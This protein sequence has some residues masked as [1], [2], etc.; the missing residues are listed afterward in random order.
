MKRFPRRDPLL[1]IRCYEA[2]TDRLLFDMKVPNPGYQSSVSEWSPEAL[3]ASKTSPPV[4]AVLKHGPDDFFVNYLRDDDL[5]VTSTNPSWTLSQLQRSAWFSDATG[6]RTD[7]LVA[8][9]SPF[10]P[11]WKLTV[12]VRRNA[13]ARFAEGESWRSGLVKLPAEFTAEKLASK[14]TVAGVDFDAIW[15]C[16]AG[17]MHDHGETVTVH[18]SASEHFNQGD[19]NG[20]RILDFHRSTGFPSVIHSGHPFLWL[21]HPILA[22]N[23]ELLITVRYQNGVNISEEK[24]GSISRVGKVTRLIQLKPTPE[25]T[26]VQLEIIVNQGRTFEFLVAPPKPV[27]SDAGSVSPAFPAKSSVGNSISSAI[28]K[29]NSSAYGRDMK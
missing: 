26:D 15:L 28:A 13:M 8:E 6:N 18:P 19:R 27:E 9:L 2:Q 16:S 23:T 1:Q 4:T 14:Q 21:A 17:T 10:E 22:G 25:T 24:N 7:G 12:Q 3:P 5:E 11:A 20:I 29:S